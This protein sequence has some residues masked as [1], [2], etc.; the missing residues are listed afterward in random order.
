MIASPREQHRKRNSNGD[1][2]P[3]PSFPGGMRNRK[4]GVIGCWVFGNANMW[5]R[6]ENPYGVREEQEMEPGGILRRESQSWDSY[7]GADEPCPQRVRLP[8]YKPCRA[9]NSGRIVFL[10]SKDKSCVCLLGTHG[11]DTEDPKTDS[12][13]QGYWSRS[14]HCKERER[15]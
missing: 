3:C 12:L 10:S 2:E 8:G 14:K 11:C 7:M 15:I 5:V 6:R 4:R 9:N 13:S 1:I